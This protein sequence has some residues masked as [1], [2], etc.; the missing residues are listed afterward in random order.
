LKSKLTKLDDLTV[1]G[2]F[3][4]GEDLAQSGENVEGV[5]TMGW[6]VLHCWVVLCK[7]RGIDLLDVRILEEGS[8]GPLE[9]L[10]VVEDPGPPSP[11]SR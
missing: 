7:F 5:A 11:S 4:P 8:E 2:E 10:Q 6:R 9:C 1:G 3:R